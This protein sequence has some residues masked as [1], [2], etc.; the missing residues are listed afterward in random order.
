[1]RER[2]RIKREGGT[3]E[4]GEGCDKECAET[5]S[6]AV[7]VRSPSVIFFTFTKSVSNIG[8]MGNE[9]YDIILLLPEEAF[10]AGREL[11]VQ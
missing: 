11:F 4:R 8:R 7:W 6:H 1:M 5:Q 3:E 2:G 10:L 9:K